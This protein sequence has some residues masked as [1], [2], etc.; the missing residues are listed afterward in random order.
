MKKEV[1]FA[2]VAIPVALIAI[3]LPRVFAWDG[4]LTTSLLG[5]LFGAGVGFLVV[6]GGLVF[7]ARRSTRLPF[8]AVI[9]LMVEPWLSTLPLPNW[10]SWIALLTIIAAILVLAFDV[11]KQITQGAGRRDDDVR[12]G[13]LDIW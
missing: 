7:K 12:R 5:L 9:W 3:T 10:S 11:W 2:I 6:G 1:V 8:F 4:S 13:G